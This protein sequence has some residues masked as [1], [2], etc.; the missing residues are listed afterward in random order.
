MF[1][2]QKIKVNA[3]AAVLAVV[4]SAASVGAAV[5]PARAVE[6]GPSLYASAPVAS[7]HA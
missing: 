5:G 7:T 2:Y 6:T 1:D 3:A 4:L